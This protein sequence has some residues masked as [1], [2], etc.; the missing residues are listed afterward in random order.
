MN[1][2]RQSLLI[3]LP[4][5][6]L[7]LYSVPLKGAESATPPNIILIMADD[8][9]FS[10]LGCYGSEINTPNLDRLAA[11]GVRWT[12]FYNNAKCTT[13]RASLIT[14]LTPRRQSKNLL[15][16]N[17]VTIAEVLKTAGYR[18]ALTGKWHLGS[19]APHRPSD[20]GFDHYYGLLDGCCNFFDPSI[21][22]PEFK[23]GRT[24]VFAE[25]DQLI[26]EFPEDYYTTTAF[27]EAA[28]KF[29]NESSQTDEPFFLHVCYTAPHYPLH[30]P[31]EVVQRYLGQ[32][33]HGW[34]VLRRKRSQKQ[35]DMGLFASNWQSAGP[36]NHVRNWE[37]LEHQEWEDRRMA[38]YAAMI[39]VMDQEIG[40]IVESLA[41][42]KI[43]ENTVI[44]FLSDNGG[45]AETPGGEDPSRK[46]GIKETY[47]TCG[48]G[49]AYASN[50][51]F[52][53]Y[54]QWVH[55]G[56][57]STPFIVHWPGQIEAG[58]YNRNVGHIIDILPTCAEL[59]GATYPEKFKGQ[60]VDPVEGVSL[61]SSFKSNR[62]DSELNDRAL[63]WEWGGNRAVREGNWKLCWDREFKR[64]ELYDLS[65]DR[66]ELHDL[67]AEH[68][69]RVEQ[70]SQKWSFWAKRTGVK[71][72]K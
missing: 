25:D 34:E 16:P 42:N 58:T 9:G 36:D 47:T 50:T 51:P 65:R 2:Y 39:D 49:W 56:G 30:A 45:C 14:G 68:P 15:T 40:R 28:L 27:T 64:W 52:R 55:E 60:P 11:S 62:P 7:G 43:S 35:L 71:I 10:D 72:R 26:H 20:R 31:E 67:A 1:Y 13:T 41:Q 61:V 37:P 5:I 19:R 8:M 59:A 3:W 12:Q 66:T 22:D 70:L 32:Y 23:G 69:E 54:K 38:V 21:P 63:Y 17:V 57:I 44:M 33:K 4:L 48:P 6:A 18:T 46:P 24:R 29:I 53:R